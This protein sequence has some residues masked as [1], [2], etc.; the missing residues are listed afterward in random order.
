M[1]C[2]LRVSTTLLEAHPWQV[3]GLREAHPHS[4]RASRLFSSTKWPLRLQRACGL[5]ILGPKSAAW[6]IGCAR[7][8]GRS[9]Q[10]HTLEDSTSKNREN[11][12][13]S[14]VGNAQ[15]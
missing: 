12:M 13:A 15:H 2:A 14:H 10:D 8:I 5:S 4:I 6:L 3:S 7:R 9:F 11:E 1:P